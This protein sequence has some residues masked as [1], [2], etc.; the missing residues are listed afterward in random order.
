MEKIKKRI[1]AIYERFIRIRETPE[2]LA[3]GVAI[4]FFVAMTPTMG[5]QTYLVVP[6]AALLGISKITAAAGVWI[7]NP[8]TAPFVYAFNYLIGAR[9]LGYPLNVDLF[10]NPTRETI[11]GAGKQVFIALSVGGTLTGV[12]IGGAGYYATLAVIRTARGCPDS[13]AADR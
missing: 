6:L 10:T 9:V 2:Q 7:T 12:V 3:W 5:F 11:L 8:I 4:G 13:R 1:L